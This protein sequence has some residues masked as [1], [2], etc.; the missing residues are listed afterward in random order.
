[1]ERTRRRRPRGVAARAGRWSAGHRKTAIWGW[2]AFVVAAIAI[3]GALGTKT[4]PDSKSGDGE[5]ATPNR[6]S[7]AASTKRPPSRC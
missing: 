7:N 5:S 4:L 2:I 1:M 3:G 6:R